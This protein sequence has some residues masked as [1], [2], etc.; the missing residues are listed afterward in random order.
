MQDDHLTLVTTLYKT[1]VS[2]AVTWLSGWSTVTK[3]SLVLT[4]SWPSS[5][6]SSLYWLTMELGELGMGLPSGREV[7]WP[8]EKMQWILTAN[9]ASLTHISV[10]CVCTQRPAG[11]ES[12]RSALETVNEFRIMFFTK[13]SAVFNW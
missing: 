8:K 9:T 11:A 10:S 4:A 2:I 6:S 7:F 13:A 12:L 3:M 5:S 1:N